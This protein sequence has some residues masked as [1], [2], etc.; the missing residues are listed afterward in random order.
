V[1][2]QQRGDND[3]P[4][5]QE[6][7]DRK[8][9]GTA[10][11][12]RLRHKAGEILDG[13]YREILWALNGVSRGLCHSKFTAWLDMEATA[14]ES[15]K[16]QRVMVRITGNNVVIAKKENQGDTVDVAICKDGQMTRR[17]LKF[18]N[19]IVPHEAAEERLRELESGVKGEIFV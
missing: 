1:S 2:Q 16:S 11:T 19:A 18:E 4:S 7:F 12:A 10:H 5:L 6:E 17:T 9:A 3:L 14:M 15:C 13:E 8:L